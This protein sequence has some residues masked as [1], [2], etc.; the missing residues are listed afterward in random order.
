MS[1]KDD[2]WG[3]RKEGIWNVRSAFTPVIDRAGRGWAIGRADEY[4]SGF[5]PIPEK[6]TFRTM[7]AAQKVADDMNK[8]IGIT[9]KEAL[10]IV[11][12]SM[13]Q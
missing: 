12:T 9:K 10:I 8:E 1:W 7:Q 3:V 4:Q 2:V 5:T 13:R 6:G 11:A